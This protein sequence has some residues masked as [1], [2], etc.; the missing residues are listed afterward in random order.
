MIDVKST[1]R[2]IVISVVGAALFRGLIVVISSFSTSNSGSSIEIGIF[3]NL[4]VQVSLIAVFVFI[5]L[6]L[7]R[8]LFEWRRKQKKP[9]PG[10]PLA[11]AR[12]PPQNVLWGGYIDKYGVKWRAKYGYNPHGSN[13][14]TNAYI[15]GPFCPNCGTELNTGEKKPTYSWES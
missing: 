9:D 1:L 4:L 7:I 2:D 10:P 13:Y 15:K 12:N 8:R 14:S 3:N 5:F 11:V 6:V